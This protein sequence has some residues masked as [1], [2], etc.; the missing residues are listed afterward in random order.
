MDK[1]KLIEYDFIDGDIIINFISDYGYFDA[2]IFYSVR[3]NMLHKLMCSDMSLILKI[4][5]Y[6]ETN[7][8]FKGIEI[9]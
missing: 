9:E 5:T 6:L 1:V 3:Y 2:Q 4:K 8:G 7:F